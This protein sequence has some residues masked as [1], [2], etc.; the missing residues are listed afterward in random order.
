MHTDMTASEARSKIYQLFAVLFTYPDE[1]LWAALTGNEIS[2]QFS[3][4]CRALPFEPPME[5][6]HWSRDLEDTT[7]ENI[8]SVY[9]SNFEIGNAPV[10]LYERGYTDTGDAAVFEEL[11]RFYEYFGL[12]FDQGKMADWPDSLLVELEFMHYLSFLE[13]KRDCDPTGIRKAQKDFLERHLLPLTSRL[14]DTL[15]T[16]CLAHYTNLAVMMRRFVDA[17]FDH[18]GSPLAHH[19]SEAPAK[20]ERKR[21]GGL[22]Q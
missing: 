9:T 2:R 16:K 10:S 8:G 7:L 12:S 5:I 21:E 15:L 11:Y 1:A 14:S 6:P 22:K 18:L 4:A 3:D 20:G 17:D 19:A 13:A